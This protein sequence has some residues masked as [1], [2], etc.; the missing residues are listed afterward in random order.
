MLQPRVVEKEKVKGGRKKNPKL[1]R[2]GEGSAPESCLLLYN[3]G[4]GERRRCNGPRRGYRRG[5]GSDFQAGEKTNKKSTASPK[6]H[7]QK[8]AV[9]RV[10]ERGADGEDPGGASRRRVQGVV[11]GRSR[12]G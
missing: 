4:G 8:E 1:G 6:P 2:K 5:T 10:S 3:L 9:L 11:G 12:D 7:K